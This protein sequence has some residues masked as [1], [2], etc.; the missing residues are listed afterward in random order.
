[1]SSAP[2]GRRVVL[3]EGGYDLMALADSTA[4]AVGALAGIDVEPERPTCGGPGHE[5]V[6]AAHRL[7]SDV[8]GR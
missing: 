5:V 6:V 8:I 3:L 1:M 2:P 7:W 4:A